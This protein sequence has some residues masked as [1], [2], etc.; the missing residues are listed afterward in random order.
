MVLTLLYGKSD[1]CDLPIAV[2]E[3]PVVATPAIGEI[4]LS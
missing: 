1:S 3:L 4:L 2:Q